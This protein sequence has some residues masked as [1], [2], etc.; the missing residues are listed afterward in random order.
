MFLSYAKDAA[1]EQAVIDHEVARVTEDE[2][3]RGLPLK[4]N[5]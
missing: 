5:K 4:L 1:D 2:E 3:K